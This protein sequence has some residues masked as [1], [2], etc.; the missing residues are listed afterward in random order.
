MPSNMAANTKHTTLLKLNAFPLRV[1]DNFVCSVNFWHQQDS[2]SDL[3]IK[4]ALFT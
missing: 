1:E 3:F 4:E 2:N